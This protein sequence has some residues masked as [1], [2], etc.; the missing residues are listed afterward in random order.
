MFDHSL[1]VRDIAT[2]ALNDNPESKDSHSS[3]NS[4]HS[5]ASLSGLIADLATSD[6]QNILGGSTFLL[7]LLDVPLE[8][9]LQLGFL[10]YLLDWAAF[11]GLG[12]MLILLPIPTKLS[13]A[14]ARAQATRMAATDERVSAVSEAM[15]VIRMLKLSGYTGAIREDVKEKREK[16]LKQVW[17]LKLVDAIGNIT[18]FAL[19]LVYM[20]V[21]YAIFVSFHLLRRRNSIS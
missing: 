3:E 5:K 19:P 4:G 8:L 9:G 2:S 6:L 18:S 7:V 21:S 10:Y 17:R 20:V 16:E 1:R 12:A 11:A 13:A 14:I 15:S